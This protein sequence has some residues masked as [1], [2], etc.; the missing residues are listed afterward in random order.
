MNTLLRKSG[1]F[2]LFSAFFVSSVHAAN[3]AQTELGTQEVEGV[4][5]F[6]SLTLTLD[7]KIT[8]LHPI[9]AGLRKKKIVLFWAKV[10]VIQFFASGE[11]LEGSPVSAISLTLKRDLTST[12]IRE[13]FGHSLKTNGYDLDSPDFKPIA[14]ALRTL[15][16]LKDG[17]TLWIG[18]AKNPDESGTIYLENAKGDLQN[19]VV[20]PGVIGQFMSIWWGKPSDSGMEALQEELKAKKT[21]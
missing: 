7:G 1:Y 21:P 20:K 8:P 17:S 9:A 13:G 10:Y 11:N 3:I 2:L 12:Q 16:N 4:K 6:K 18:L 19:I 15:G 14:D 5:L